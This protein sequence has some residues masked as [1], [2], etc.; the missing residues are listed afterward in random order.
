MKDEAW[1]PIIKAIQPYHTRGWKI[2]VKR[3]RDKWTTWKAY[4]NIYI[5]LREPSGMGWDE[6]RSSL[7]LRK[8]GLA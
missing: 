1:T 8:S 3:C 2:T 5:K 7:R 4:F 6:L